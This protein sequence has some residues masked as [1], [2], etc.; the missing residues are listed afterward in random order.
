MLF[1]FIRYIYT[2]ANLLDLHSIF[3][4]CL[5]IILFVWQT[6][7]KKEWF[8]HFFLKQFKQFNGLDSLLFYFRFYFFLVFLYLWILCKITQVA[9]YPDL[10]TF[11]IDLLWLLFNRKCWIFKRKIM[12]ASENEL[13]QDDSSTC[14]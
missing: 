11:L 12:A 10:C 6:K 2:K 9:A 7:E 4:I 8:F 1:L 5:K 14:I 3:F 13:I